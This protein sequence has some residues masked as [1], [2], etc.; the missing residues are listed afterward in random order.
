MF[1]LNGDFRSMI[2]TFRFQLKLYKTGERLVDRMEFE[3]LAL[4]SIDPSLGPSVANFKRARLKNTRKET[5]ELEMEQPK[6][7][8]T[9][10]VYCPTSNEFDQ[11]FRYSIL[12]QYCRLQLLYPSCWPTPSIEYQSTDEV[13]ISGC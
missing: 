11:S 6:V 5:G 7:S 1:L 9:F 12:L 13:S 3:E 2:I 4:K 10:F 8:S